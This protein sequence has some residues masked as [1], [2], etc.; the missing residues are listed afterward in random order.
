[1]QHIEYLILLGIVCLF[2]PKNWL[3]ILGIVS[4]ALADT[5]LVSRHLI[6]YTRFVPMGVLALRVLTDIT[7]GRRQLK[8]QS[9]FLKTFL[10]FIILSGI[11]ILYAS[12]QNIVFQRYLSMLFVFIGFG[13]G[14]PLYYEKQEDIIKLTKIIGIIIAI[15]VIYSFFTSSAQKTTATF[16]VVEGRAQGIFKNP[17]TLGLLA[18]QNVFIIFYFWQKEQI[19]WKANLLLLTIAILGAAI[20]SS[21]SRASILGTIIGMFFFFKGYGKI[22]GKVLSKIVIFIIIAS[23]AFLLI[24]EF[25]PKYEF[26]FLRPERPG[27]VTHLSMLETSSRSIL[28]KRAWIISK[29]ARW[30]GVGFGGSAR[31]FW[32]DSLYLKSIGIFISGPHSS[33]FKL[34]VELGFTGVFFALGAFFILGK[35][36]WDMIPSC[37]DPILALALYGMIIAGLFNSMFES[38]LFGFGSS[39]TI[40][41]WLFMTILTTK[42][43]EIKY[44]KT[45]HQNISIS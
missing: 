40:P 21:G 10:P 3:I 27:D 45:L 32:L 43:D 4:V 25:F 41:F 23:I 24:V 18:M 30:F 44:K 2:L 8:Y 36:I 42:A 28:W 13:L 38:W 1:M 5:R 20:I 7:T 31:L 22:Y 29:P 39:S 14:V 9:T 33:F 16:Y 19:K 6:Y 37:E 34:L 15:G 11:S 17:N 35:K 26:A 12:D